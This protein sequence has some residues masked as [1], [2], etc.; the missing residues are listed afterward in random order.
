MTFKK[1][2]EDLWKAHLNPD[3]PRKA[4]QEV[5]DKFEFEECE[6]EF[7]SS[8][9]GYIDGFPELGRFKRNTKYRVYIEEVT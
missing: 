6:G 8:P 9:L 2:E 4:M 7:T 3:D 5:L 1:L